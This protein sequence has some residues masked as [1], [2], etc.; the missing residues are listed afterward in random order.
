MNVF[1]TLNAWKEFSHWMKTDPAKADKIVTLIDSL[2][3]DPFKGEGKPE[4]L[5]GDLSGYWSRRIS[6]ED[7]LVYA[8]SGKRGVDQVV[9]IIQCRF[10]YEP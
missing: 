1:F 6:G 4:P 2:R 9:T 5:K 3:I 10:H 8:V 7:R